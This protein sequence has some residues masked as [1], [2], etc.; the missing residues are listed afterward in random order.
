M[1]LHHEFLHEGLT[2]DKSTHEL[3]M[4]TAGTGT[5][6]PKLTLQHSMDYTMTIGNKWTQLE[7]SG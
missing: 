1:E 7:S 6:N 2:F 5:P 4:D 3:V